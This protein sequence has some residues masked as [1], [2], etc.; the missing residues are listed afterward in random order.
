MKTTPAVIVVCMLCI[1]ARAETLRVVGTAGYLSEW[2]ISGT[3]VR[4]P[5]TDGD[6]FVGQVVW[7]HVG[8]CSVNSPEEK[9]GEITFKLRQ[10]LWAAKAEARMVLDDD[11]CIYTGHFSKSLNGLMDCSSAK[12]VPLALSLE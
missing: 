12:G 2:E 9:R 11:Q 10:S 7:K 4:Q 1:P 6:Q 3:M 5:S 8:L